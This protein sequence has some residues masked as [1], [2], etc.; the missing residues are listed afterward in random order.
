MVTT[1]TLRGV[2]PTLHAKLKRRAEEHRRSLNS[3]VIALLEQAVGQAPQ[4]R[5]ALLEEIDRLREQGPTIEDAPEALKR[6]MRAG[7]L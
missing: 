6:E 4:D 3:E 1:L 7:L 2:P 5:A